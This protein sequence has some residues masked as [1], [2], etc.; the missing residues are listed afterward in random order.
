MHKYVSLTQ[1]MLKSNFTGLIPN[2]EEGDTF[3]E[4]LF[5]VARAHEYVM[6]LQWLLEFHPKDNANVIREVIDLMF[7]GAVTGGRD[8]N[9]YFSDKKFPK[10]PLTS[11]VGPDEG[12]SHGVNTAEGEP[13][14]FERGLCASHSFRTSISHRS[15]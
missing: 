6:S 8:W 2:P 14:S 12:F 11:Y 1:D 4:Y 7:E 3:D 15:V 13:I 5:G 10:E 9:E